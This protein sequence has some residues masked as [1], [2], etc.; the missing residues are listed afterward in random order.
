[1]DRRHD[2]IR[3]DGRKWRCEVKPVDQRLT[4]PAEI[5]SPASPRSQSPEQLRAAD[6]LRAV[7]DLEDD[8]VLRKKY[9]S[10]VE[11]VGPA[12]LMNGLGQAMATERAAAGSNA[13]TGDARAHAQL[14]KNLGAWLCRPGGVYPPAQ[15]KPDLL[16]LITTRTER[17]YLRAQ[18]EALAWLLWHKKFCRAYLPA[19][20]AAGSAQEET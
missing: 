17:D 20:D 18:T 19:S 4:A 7:R 14:Y 3:G 15:P 12:I 13:K 5:G 9:R 1:M 2:S 8:D 16:E 10:Y 6:A 11:R